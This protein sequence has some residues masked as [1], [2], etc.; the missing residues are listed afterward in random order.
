VA[1]AADAR[2]G[3]EAE[4]GH[5]ITDRGDAGGEW[6]LLGRHRRHGERQRRGR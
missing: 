5:S 6:P 4:L 2:P 1:I 3:R